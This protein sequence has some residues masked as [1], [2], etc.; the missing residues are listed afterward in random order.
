[1][2]IYRTSQNIQYLES[3]G[4]PETD[5]QEI[6]DYLMELE[7]DTRKYILRQIKKNPSIPLNEI[8]EIETDSKKNYLRKQGYPE[9][10]VDYATRIPQYSVWLA[11]EVKN[12]Y[13]P[14][15][16]IGTWLK[17][18]PI[19][20]QMVDAFV[21]TWGR[22]MVD[23]HDWIE[24]TNPNLMR[25]TINEAV[26]ASEEWHENLRN[27][28]SKTAYS[29]HNVVYTLPNKW[30]IVK[31][32]SG[33]CKSEGELMGNCVGG[34]GQSVAEGKTSIFSLRDPKNQ[35]HVT[36][37]I[38]LYKRE[39]D[40][41]GIEKG[42][43]VIQIQG[44]GNDEPIPEYKAMIKQWF[45]NLRQQKYTLDYQ[46]DN[47]ENISIRE[48]EDSLSER[49]DYGFNRTFSGIGGDAE[50]YYKNLEDAYQEG[51]SGSYWVARASKGYIDD[52]IAYAEIHDELDEI[53]E[54]LEGFEKYTSQNGKRVKQTKSFS[55]WADEAWFE[56]ELYTEFEN[57]R[58]DEED[59]PN[60]EDFM[61]IPDISQQQP[62]FENMPEP[63]KIFNEEAYDAAIAEYN[64][65]E[66][67]YEDELTL[68]Q[69]DFEPYVFT[70]HLYKAIE[71]AK[72]RKNEEKQRI[73]QEQQG[74][75]AKTRMKMYKI[76]DKGPLSA[77]ESANYV[78]ALQVYGQEHPSINPEYLSLIKELPSPR[79]IRQ[80]FSHEECK[81]LYETI[82][83][84][85]K[86]LTGEDI[87]EQKDII[88]APETLFGNY[89]LMK[90]GI[91]LKGVN[92]FTIIKHNSSL[93]CTL[94]N[95]NGMTLQEYLSSKPNK[96]IEFILKNGGVRMFIDKN[97]RLY[98]QMSS[99]TYGKFGKS[100]IKKYDFPKKIVK[101]IDFKAPYNGW[102]SGVSIKL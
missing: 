37:E 88:N 72:Q 86:K 47:Y 42:M 61:I 31:M 58:P 62:E 49:D 98:A 90:N 57:P 8:K 16:Y 17:N 28:E 50:T 24:Q 22:H 29:S 1:M 11:R 67:A 85:W 19:G 80:D 73:I 79:K 7:G 74:K 102:E 3:I 12:Y 35:P 68:Y 34:Y 101:V 91:L 60:K 77:E 69:E 66:K 4:V 46:E 13:K 23:T 30:E 97:K 45:D 71:A 15:R 44:K 39:E 14:E 59:Y 93:I 87:I 83:Y 2:R 53:Q 70:N 76:A 6:L 48:L 43:E 33:D 20:Q 52:L 18:K 10:V 26:E 63:Q 65:K 36:M 75:A 41:V 64:A 51:I 54:A 27:Q 96:L 82:G 5:R 9:E 25:F 94:L 100:K 21:L 99:E 40:P 56:N 84:L 92:H 55:E 81:I 89:W 95:I 32:E 78:E 38:N